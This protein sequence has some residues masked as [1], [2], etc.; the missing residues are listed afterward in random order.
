[1]RPRDRIIEN[2]LAISGQG[3]DP[4]QSAKCRIAREIRH[5]PEPREESRLGGIERGSAQFIAKRLLC[6]IDGGK[7]GSRRNRDACG[8]EHLSFPSLRSRMIHFNYAQIWEGIAASKC[9]ETC[10]ENDALPH[11]LPDRLG[12]PVLRETAAG[13]HE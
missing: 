10:S 9:V 11:P 2:H 13:H 4:A 8:T 6:E 12:K 3:S 1:M 7:A 5:H